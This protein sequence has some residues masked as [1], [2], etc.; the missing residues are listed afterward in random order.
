MLLIQAAFGLPRVHEPGMMPWITSF[1]KQSPGHSTNLKNGPC[2]HQSLATNHWWAVD[3]AVPLEVH[4]ISVCLRVCPRRLKNCWS[5]S[6][7]DVT[8]DED[9]IFCS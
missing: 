5:D 2:A 7:V 8:C 1:S 3:L 4:S 6:E 9:R